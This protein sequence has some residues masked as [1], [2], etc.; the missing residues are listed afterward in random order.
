MNEGK[1]EFTYQYS[2]IDPL[3]TFKLPTDLELG[4]VLEQFEN[5][6]LAS[7][8]RFDGHIDIVDDENEVK[9]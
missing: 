6:L 7:G 4:A 2:D 8:Y 1:M 9:E 3:I 5:F